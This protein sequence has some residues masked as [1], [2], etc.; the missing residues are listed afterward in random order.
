MN[1]PRNSAESATPPEAPKLEEIRLIDY[2][3]QKYGTAE[4]RK[5][6]KHHEERK[7]DGPQTGVMAPEP[8]PASRPVAGGS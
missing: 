8:A 1:Q 2:N 5:R 3:F 7:G 6:R 4:E